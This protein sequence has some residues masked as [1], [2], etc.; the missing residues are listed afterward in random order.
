MPYCQKCGTENQLG[1]NFCK[2]CGLP[3]NPIKKRRWRCNLCNSTFD[4]QSIAHSHY[5]SMNQNKPKSGGWVAIIIIIII[6][7]AIIIL[8][9]MDGQQQ[10]AASF[11]GQTGSLIDKV[12]G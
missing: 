3:V 5:C 1:S 12:F 7:I 9:Y 2:N 8:M 6:V 10:Q 4:S 11:A